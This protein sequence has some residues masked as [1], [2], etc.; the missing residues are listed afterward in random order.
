MRGYP[1]WV[2][3]LIDLFELSLELDQSHALRA[4]TKHALEELLRHRNPIYKGRDQAAVMRLRAYVLLSFANFADSS[5]LWPH[6]IEVLQTAKTP[7][8]FFSCRSLSC[9]DRSTGSGCHGSS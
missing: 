3:P 1:K 6:A 5:E 9:Q 7:Y 8:E 2:T 4:K